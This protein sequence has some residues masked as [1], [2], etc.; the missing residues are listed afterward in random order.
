MTLLEQILLTLFIATLAVLGYFIKRQIERRPQLEELEHQER[1][2]RLK[3]ILVESPQITAQVKS[4]TKEALSTHRKSS[5]SR[6]RLHHD[7]EERLDSTTTQAEM[8]EISMEAARRARE[9]ID[10]LEERIVDALPS[11][12]KQYFRDAARAWRQYAE[13][14]ANFAASEYEG[15]SLSPFIANIEM[16]GLAKTRF[17][18][19]ESLF[20]EIQQV[21]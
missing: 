8:N 4:L 20:H 9:A 7:L 3:Q 13:E 19:L 5:S 14:Y 21:A 17:E 18:A 12:R 2:L 11:H 10:D 1:L 6:P 15:G 16:Y